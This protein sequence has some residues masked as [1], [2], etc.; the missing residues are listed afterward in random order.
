MAKPPRKTNRIRSILSR[1]AHS[2]RRA[3]RYRM[4]QVTRPLSEGS[5]AFCSTHAKPL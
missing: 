5:W 1:A 3:D 4:E 2:K